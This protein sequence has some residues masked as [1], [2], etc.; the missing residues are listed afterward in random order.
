[1]ADTPVV[2]A[3]AEVAV[4]LPLAGA[5]T[6]SVPANLE[7]LA[8]PGC[9]VRVAVGKRRTVGVVL[10]R[11]AA[12]P[13]GIETRPLESVLDLQ[14]V[15][16]GELLELASFVADYYMAPIGEVIR[17]MLPSA[18]PPWGDRRIWLTDAGALAAP[19]SEAE[20]AVI[21]AVREAGRLRLGELQAR[22]GL[23]DLGRIVEDLRAGGR[24]VVAEENETGARYVTAVDRAPGG[25]AEQVEAAGRSPAGRAVLE[26][27]AAQGRPA[28][29][30]ELEGEVGASAAVV[31]RLLGKGLLK[32]F[33]QVDH[34]DLDRH[35][36]AARP[37]A[38]LTPRPDQA[39]A[40][41]AL[42][43]VVGQRAF[44]GFLLVGPTGA[45]KTE[46]YLRAAQHALASGRSAILLVPEI[47]LVPALAGEARRR[48][49]GE[50]AILH[51]SLASQERH[52]EW[53][54]IRGGRARVVLGPR[55]AVFAPLRDVGLIVVDE[56]QDPAYKQETVPRYQG[57]D[58]ALVR[59]RACNA[60]VVLVSATPSFESR[61]NRE[62]GKLTGLELTAR[63]GQGRMPEGILVDL[64]AEKDVGK[65]GE[66]R[67]SARLLAELRST[68]ER[69]D[70]AI[71]LRNRRGYA[72]VLLCRACG[73]DMRCADCGLPRTYHRKQARLV[74]HYCGSRV[75]A[76]ER[77]PTCGEAAL[78]PVG[79]GT[80]RVE[81]R[82]R[83]LFPE[84]VVDVLDR[85][86]I[87]RPGGAA[88]LLARFASGEVQALIGTQM[89]SKGHHFPR[90]ALTAV[91]AADSYLSFPDFRAVERTYALLTQVAG[92]A[93]RG[94]IPGRV[95]VQTYHP[96]HYAI[97]AALENDDAGFAAEEMRFRRLFHYPPFTRMAQVLIKDRQRARGEGEIAALAARIQ[98]HPLAADL[99]VSGPAPAPFERLRGEWRFQLL[100]R[101]A[102]SSRIHELLRAT[103]PPRSASEIVVDIDPFQLL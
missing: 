72:P 57:R 9:R 33:T 55:S 86:A 23:A 20:R 50:L 17:S 97:R 48:F 4:P 13:A 56:E 36:L 51:S 68:F 79:A 29:L 94:D 28:T 19:R 32:K 42:C 27:L 90:V 14:P 53:E 25:L 7:P 101:G 98:Q 31:R 78:E 54:R 30:S 59:G 83:E 102:S 15:L 71:L 92:R 89:V 96:D 34:L 76:P 69:G 40:I 73:E 52:Q 22:T 45:G 82:F 26:Y 37:G 74:C 65:V 12:A 75:P 84:V 10:A 66:A 21:E 81:E 103:L 99:R 38:D 16:T 85:D 49:G 77:C 39:A 3:F 58:L 80:E 18:L 67:F 100:L 41:Q 61:H 43:D 88:A 44:A 6:Y 11:R 87:R 5:L 91:L 35:L 93:G 46:V 70:Q 64:R 47:A 8:R 95:V 24:V 60:A 1:V 63:A 62:R 2:A